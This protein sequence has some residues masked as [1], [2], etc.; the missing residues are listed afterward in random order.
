MVKLRISTSKFGRLTGK[1]FVRMISYLCERKK[2]PTEVQIIRIL[3]ELVV[4]EVDLALFLLNIDRGYVLDPERAQSFKKRLPTR[5]GF[6]SGHA[7]NS[8][9]FEVDIFFTVLVWISGPRLCR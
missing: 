7:S 5:V 9:A 1:F 6:A 8:K 2:I 3:S 4:C